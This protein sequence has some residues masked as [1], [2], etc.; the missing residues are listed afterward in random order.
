M[1]LSEIETFLMIV[2]TRNITKTAENLFLSQPTVSH[3]LK[4]LE[5]ELGMQLISRNKGYKLIELTPQG[6]EFVPLAQRWV[7]IWK[8]TQ[9]LQEGKERH[10]LSIGCTDTLSNTIMA[11]FYQRLLQEDQ[12]LDLRIKT[13]QSE[14][15]YGL[16]ERHEIDLGFVYHH[17]HF[18]NTNME[19]ILSEKMYI[20]Q[21]GNVETKKSKIFLKE[22]D[23]EKELFFSW[24][25][26]YQIWHDQYVESS[27]RPHIQIDSF[28]LILSLLPMEGAWMIMPA[29]VIKMLTKYMPVQVSEI[30]DEKKPQPR[31]TY[32]VRHKTPNQMTRKAVE[33]F[34]ERLDVYLK[35]MHADIYLR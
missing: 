35:E 13:H 21:A 15:I 14:E 22:L 28:G 7:G 27:K 2:Q 8:E 10:Y 19:P 34:E 23:S 30:A 12:N 20:V 1:N 11:P 24:E 31:L 26:N 16:L 18:K 17:L 25:T 32:I 3:R 9:L 33:Q 5:E 4:S 6:E 29:S